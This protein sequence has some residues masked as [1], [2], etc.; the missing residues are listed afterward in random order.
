M[1]IFRALKAHPIQT[2][3]IGGAALWG[4][5]RWQDKAIEREMRVVVDEFHGSLAQVPLSRAIASMACGLFDSFHDSCSASNLEALMGGVRCF[6]GLH[7][8]WEH[9]PG[10]HGLNTVQEFVDALAQETDG[11]TRGPDE[12]HA[13][14]ARAWALE[15]YSQHRFLDDWMGVLQ[16]ANR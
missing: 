4:D 9:R 1:E 16:Y 15:N 5:A 2:V 6:Y 13:A 3:Y 14:A 10:V 11:F 8:C 12:N 7:G